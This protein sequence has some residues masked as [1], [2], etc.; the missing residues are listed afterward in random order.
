MA[1]VGSGTTSVWESPDLDCTPPK[2]STNPVLVW[3]TSGVFPPIT[4]HKPYFLFQILYLQTHLLKLIW[5]S[6]SMAVLS[7]S[8]GD[9][10]RTAK[11]VSR[12]MHTF[13][14]E[15]GQGSTLPCLSSR[16]VRKFPFGGLFNA[17]FSMIVCLFGW[18]S[19][20]NWPPGSTEVLTSALKHSTT[21]TCLTQKLV[22]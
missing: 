15:G 22:C 5:T 10:H 18:F 21:R 8:P 20:L 2:P 1:C 17:M 12:Q 11:D 9:M 7:Q 16:D 4:I 3:T 19:C 14:T 6:K 13:P